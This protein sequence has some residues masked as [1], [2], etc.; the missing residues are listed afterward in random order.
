MPTDQ[1]ASLVGPMVELNENGGQG[2]DHA[3]AKKLLT[4]MRLTQIVQQNTSLSCKDQR[5][6]GMV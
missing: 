1:S 6:A 2:R 5:P 4:F 3:S